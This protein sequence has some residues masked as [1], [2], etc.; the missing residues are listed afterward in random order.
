MRRIYLN[1]PLAPNTTQTLSDE[2]F[3]YAVRVLRCRD[4]ERLSVFNG[5]GHDYIATLALTGKK[6]ADIQISEAIENSKESPLHTVLIQGLSKGE[7]MDIVMQKAV[8][9]GVNEIIPVRTTFCAVKLDDKR[10]AKKMQHWQSIVTS[11][12]E[13]SERAVVPTL[14]PLQSLSDALEAVETEFKWMLHPYPVDF[15]KVDH[16]D[17]A[18]QNR[19]QNQIQTHAQLFSEIKPASVAI[20]VGPEGGFSDEEVELAMSQN[21][22]AKA[23]GSRILRTETAAISAL[24]ICQQYWGDWHV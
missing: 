24:S 6:H 12:C 5:D 11:A 2:A 8:E 17:S 7:R 16:V 15:L 10:L 3:H 21:V 13:Q 9:L 4:G 20:L 19:M 18:S 23:L 14:H 1:A 22:V